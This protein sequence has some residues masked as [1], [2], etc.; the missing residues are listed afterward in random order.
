M[1]KRGQAK[2]G[3]KQSLISSSDNRKGNGEVRRR[4]VDRSLE[5]SSIL[6]TS[7]GDHRL[8]MTYHSKC[9]LLIWSA[10]FANRE[11]SLYAKARII[12]GFLRKVSA[13]LRCKPGN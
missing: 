2:T 12:F 3:P 1:P 5:S 9:C 6:I 7:M 10:D 8:R 4:R 11:R 13:I